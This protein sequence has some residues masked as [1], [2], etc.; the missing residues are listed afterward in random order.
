MVVESG[1]VVGN[2]KE[3]RGEIILKRKGGLILTE[4]KRAKKERK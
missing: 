3:K 1:Y 2:L 4:K